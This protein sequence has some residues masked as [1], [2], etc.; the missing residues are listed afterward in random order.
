MLL[1]LLLVAD[2]L[3][4]EWMSSG[5]LAASEAHSTRSL[6]A[7]QWAAMRRETALRLS[8]QADT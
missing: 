5:P 3:V 6:E 7:E 2:V 8:V 1:F 4:P